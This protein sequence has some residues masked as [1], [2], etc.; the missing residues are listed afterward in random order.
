MFKKLYRTSIVTAIL[1][2]SSCSSIK[3]KYDSFDKQAC[4]EYERQLEFIEDYNFFRINVKDSDLV[5][6]RAFFE[7]LTGDKST[8]DIQFDGQLP[9]NLKDYYN[10]TAWY[11]INHNQLRYDKKADSIF[12]ITAIRKFPRSR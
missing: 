11:S 9:P 3:I 8:A 10:W 1:I 2:L 12:V 4:R 7:K 6:A 5:K